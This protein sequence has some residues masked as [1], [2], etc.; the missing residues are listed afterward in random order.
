MSNGA[1][2]FIGLGVGLFIGWLI[3]RARSGQKADLSPLLSRLENLEK[4]NERTE[5]AVKEEIARQREENAT[6]ARALREELSATLKSVGDSMVNSLGEIGTA[7]RGQLETFSSQL[8]KLVE[9]NEK[10][11]GELRNGG[12]NQARA[13]PNGQRRE[14]GRDAQDGG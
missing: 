3:A 12:R 5:R 7:Q 6:Q 4:G 13:N 11:L 8:T 10:K 1:Y 9:T 14:T 2:L